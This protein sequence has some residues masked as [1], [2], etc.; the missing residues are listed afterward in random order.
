VSKQ[1]VS[2]KDFDGLIDKMGTLVAKQSEGPI[3]PGPNEFENELNC[4]HMH[5]I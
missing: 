2:G 3:E 1:K 5:F 4:Y